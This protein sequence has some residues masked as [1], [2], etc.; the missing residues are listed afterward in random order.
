MKIN[1]NLDLQRCFPQYSVV[2]TVG[3]NFDFSFFMFCYSQKEVSFSA[4][5]FIPFTIL[6]C[7]PFLHLEAV[8]KFFFIGV[9][10]QFYNY[11]IEN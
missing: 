11:N 7:N 4:P 5:I 1:F 9:F 3:L 2:N 10:P 6:H 8:F